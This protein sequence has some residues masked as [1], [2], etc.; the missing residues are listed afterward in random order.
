MI[1]SASHGGPGWVPIVIGAVILAGLGLIR[2]LPPDSLTARALTSLLQGVGPLRSDEE[3]V[4]RYVT[5]ALIIVSSASIVIG[6]VL[7]ATGH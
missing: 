7:E 6:I 1:T 4:P 5:V 3:Y 2:L